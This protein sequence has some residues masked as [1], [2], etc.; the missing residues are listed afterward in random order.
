M[1]E[2][3]C[4]KGCDERILRGDLAQ[5]VC[6]C[7]CPKCP[8]CSFENLLA[9]TITHLTTYKG[10]LLNCP[11]GCRSLHSRGMMTE[12]L[13]VCTEELVPCK[14]AA[15]GCQAM[16]KRQQLQTHLDETKDVHLQMS[17]DMV[18][19]LATVVTLLR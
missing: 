7:A 3:L 2:V 14:Y 8:H 18:M 6:T 15:I 16:I 5:H 19:E 13:A 12:H 9:V 1:E 17:T 11:V 4:P 10:F